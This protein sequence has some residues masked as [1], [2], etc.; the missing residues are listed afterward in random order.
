MVAKKKVAKKK[1]AKKK[2]STSR[3]P[4]IGDLE[5]IQGMLWNAFGAGAGLMLEPEVF[6]TRE[7][8]TAYANVQRDLHEWVNNKAFLRRGLYCSFDAGTEAAKLALKRNKRTI[9]API[10]AEA[11]KI[12][13]GQQEEKRKRLLRRGN[14]LRGNIC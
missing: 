6:E 10:Y 9:T 14:N 3:P 7:A 1:V 8:R 2:S 13:S 12:V 5:R 4:K 11:Y